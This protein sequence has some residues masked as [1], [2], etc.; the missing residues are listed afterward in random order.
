MSI[1]YTA[2]QEA[3]AAE[4]ERLFLAKNNLQYRLQ[5]SD[6]Y[7]LSDDTSWA[8][9]RDQ[10]WP[11]ITCDAEHGGLGL[12]LI[13]AGIV[14]EACGAAL[15]GTPFLA[16]ADMAIQAVTSR[17]DREV[18][19]EWLA[20]VTSGDAR[21][22][23]ALAEPGDPLPTHPTVTFEAGTLS[24]GKPG[25]AG[26]KDADWALVWARAEHGLVLVVAKLN[27]DN[28][29]VI[30]SFD[31]ARGHADLV[32]EDAPARAV[33]DGAEAY[34]HVLALL[35]RGAVLA[36]H[37]QVGGA[38][39]LLKLGCEYA[40]SRKA[41]GQPIGA[42]QSVKHKLAELYGLIEVAR[43]NA[44]HAASREGEADFVIAAAAARLSATEAYDAAARDIVQIHGGIGVTWETGLHLHMR[45][46][47]SLA[48]E[49]GNMMFW[50]DVLLSQLEEEAA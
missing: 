42:F 7:E 49:Q 39:A 24:G 30:D 32:F 4:T 16:G 12:G 45:R 44:I 5:L 25:V 41:F 36:A 19:R 46:A 17:S 34:H 29:R 35:A 21:V 1:L 31:N 48:S 18:E 20:S 15:R 23:L 22:C 11:S 40:N 13:E 28:R 14:A 27:T 33:L 47:R 37:E 10:A 2:E 3:I 26:G 43:A 38:Q 50:E 9:M 8:V 6:N